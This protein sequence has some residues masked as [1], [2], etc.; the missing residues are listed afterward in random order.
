MMRMITTKWTIIA[1]A[2]MLV[3]ASPLAAQTTVPLSLG[4]AVT[5][6]A[7]ETAP[8]GLAGLRVDEAEARV[9]EAR[10]ALLPNLSVAAAATNRT[11]NVDAFGFKLP[12]AP[13]VEHQPLV[14]PVDNVDARLRLTQPLFDP[15][16]LLRT[17]TAREAVKGSSAEQSSAAEA[18]AQRAAL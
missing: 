1:T 8:V 10:S 15:A 16:S 6:A 14:G 5:R 7:E 18:A 11:F 4:D 2:G 17:R 9:D 13:G 3:V 12:T